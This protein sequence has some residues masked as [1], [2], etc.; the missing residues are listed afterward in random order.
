[1]SAPLYPYQGHGEG[2]HMAEGRVHPWMGRW[3]IT[4]HFVGSLPCSRVPGQWCEGDLAP[5]PT[6]K[7]SSMFCPQYTENCNFDFI[8]TLLTIIMISFIQQLHF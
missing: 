1:M 2:A 4:G 6:T 5:S 3:L 7:T 8:E